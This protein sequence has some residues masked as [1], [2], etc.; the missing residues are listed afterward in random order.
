M[1][2]CM[3]ACIH[4]QRERDAHTHTHTHTHRSITNQEKEYLMLEIEDG[5]GD[6][7]SA[8]RKHFSM[9]LM[10]GHKFSKVLSVLT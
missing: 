7:E 3:H 1:H 10:T 6:I 9:E 8:L 4:K 5:I 2:A